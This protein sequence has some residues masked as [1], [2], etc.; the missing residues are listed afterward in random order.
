VVKGRIL[1]SDGHP[2][3]SARIVIEKTFKTPLWPGNPSGKKSI[4]ERF[5]AS[6]PVRRDGTFVWHVNPST[7]PIVRNGKESYKLSVML[8]CNYGYVRKLVIDRG[9]VV[10]IGSIRIT[11]T[12]DIGCRPDHHR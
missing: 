12:T 5:K 6:I 11:S 4:T 10:N 8:S 9:D 3:R 7:R 2:Y 1:N